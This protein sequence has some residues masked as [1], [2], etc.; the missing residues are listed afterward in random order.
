M[1]GIIDRF[2]GKFVVVE[3]ENNKVINIEKTKV[4][5]EAR[6]GDVLI[7]GDEISIDLEKTK[8][9]KKSIEDLNNDLWK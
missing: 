9:R 8:I 4:P 3:L 5:I 2:E 6:E 7:I 1:F